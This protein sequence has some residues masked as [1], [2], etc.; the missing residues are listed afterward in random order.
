MI[1][2][3]KTSINQILLYTNE[4]VQPCWCIL[5][6]FDEE[7]AIDGDEESD[8]ED[9]YA[10]RSQ[11]HGGDTGDGAWLS[12]PSLFSLSLRL[13]ILLSEQTSPPPITKF[14]RR[15]MSDSFTGFARN[16]SAPSSRHLSIK[17]KRSPQFEKLK[18]ETADKSNHEAIERLV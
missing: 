17:K 3:Q 13:L 4:S 16:S 15:S 10:A 1:M 18:I 14:F 2:G 8:D 11:L 6:L 12:S 7:G 5:S 9:E